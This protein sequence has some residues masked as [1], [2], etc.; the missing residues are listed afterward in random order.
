MNPRRNVG[1]AISCKELVELVT[2]Y[3]EG[4]LPSL[5]RAY[6]ESHLTECP[7]CTEYLAQL[8]LTLSLIGHLEEESLQ[9][10]IRE[11]LLEAFRDWERRQ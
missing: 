5:E 10:E 6:F 9:P 2:E 7:G 11:R 8:R 4:T 3:L 1:A